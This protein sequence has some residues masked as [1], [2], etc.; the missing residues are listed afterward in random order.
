MIDM[1]AHSVRSSVLSLELQIAPFSVEKYGALLSDKQSGELSLFI[2][3][4]Q[5]S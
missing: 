5:F 4:C 2:N 3:I 1:V